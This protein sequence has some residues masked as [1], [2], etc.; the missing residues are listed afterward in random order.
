LIYVLKQQ[1]RGDFE[2]AAA[3]QGSGFHLNR[4]SPAAPWNAI[5]GTRG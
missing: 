5:D 2:R 3:H 4:H 1:S